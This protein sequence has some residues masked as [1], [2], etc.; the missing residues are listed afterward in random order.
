LQVHNIDSTPFNHQQN[1]KCERSWRAIEMARKENDL[2]ALVAEHNRM[3]HFGFHFHKYS[4]LKLRSKL[5]SFV[6]GLLTL[7]ASEL[8]WMWLLVEERTSVW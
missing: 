2:S 1:G 7:V 4:S 3:P 6:D 5:K 8:E